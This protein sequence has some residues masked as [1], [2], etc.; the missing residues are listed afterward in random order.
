MLG[1]LGHGDIGHSGCCIQGC[2]GGILCNKVGNSTGMI[3]VFLTAIL[4]R[5]QKVM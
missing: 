3:I 2:M 1:D 5:L 4:A